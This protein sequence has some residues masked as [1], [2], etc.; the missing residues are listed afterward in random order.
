MRLAISG[1]SKRAVCPCAG[2]ARTINNV[3]TI[4]RSVAWFSFLLVLQF[5]VLSTIKN[6]ALQIDAQTAYIRI[7]RPL[8]DRLFSGSSG[9]VSIINFAAN[10]EAKRCKSCSTGEISKSLMQ[11][12]M[13]NGLTVKRVDITK[14]RTIRSRS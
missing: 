5:S 12:L 1:A 13:L 4:K 3:P 11:F 7:K 6:L 14:E 2:P 10:L 8:N 9:T